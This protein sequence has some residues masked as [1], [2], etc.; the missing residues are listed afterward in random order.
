LLRPE[1]YLRALLANSPDVISVLNPRGLL[2]YVSPS[3][4]GLLGYEPEALLGRNAF[5]LVHPQDVAAARRAFQQV[6]KDPALKTR[7]ELRCRKPDG[8][9]CALEVLG[10]N[11]LQDPVLAGVV[12]SSRDVGKRQSAENERPESQQPLQLAAQGSAPSIGD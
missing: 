2:E 7:L 8:A 10:Q 9:W 11:R 1:P 3:V 12:F 4:T 6:L 5:S